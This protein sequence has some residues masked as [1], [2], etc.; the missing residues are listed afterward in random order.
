MLY[1]LQCPLGVEPQR[2][3]KDG[4]ISIAENVIGHR[5]WWNSAQEVVYALA[6]A[7]FLTCSH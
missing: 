5:R 7:G 2:I 6:I 3:D 1:R 4:R